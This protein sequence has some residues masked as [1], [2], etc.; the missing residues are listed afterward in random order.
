MKVNKRRARILGV[1][2]IATFVVVRAFLFM[3]PDADLNVGAYNIHHLFSGV[4]LLTACGVA[5]VLC[6][7][8]SRLNDAATAGF[9]VG[10]SLA[11]D[12]WVYLIATDGSNAAYLRPVS[13]LGGGLMVGSAAAYVWLLGALCGRTPRRNVDSRPAE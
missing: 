1:S 12:E 7:T 13:W 3:K 6:D 9:G 8:R 4:L 11:L 5:L 2:L 10:L